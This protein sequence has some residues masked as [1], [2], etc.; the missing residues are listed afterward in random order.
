MQKQQDFKKRE[1]E[2]LAQIEA[3]KSRQTELLAQIGSAATLTEDIRSTGADRMYAVVFY[4]DDVTTMDFVVELLVKVFQIAP[5]KAE[6]IMLEIHKTE[7]SV[8]GSYP[9]D[10]AITKK[11]QADQMAAERDFPLRLEIVQI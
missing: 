8:V 4:N 7:N 3:S 11:T 10:I 2:L 6:A 5:D 9:Y 1:A